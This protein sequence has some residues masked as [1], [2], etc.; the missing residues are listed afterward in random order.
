[1]DWRQKTCFTESN[2]QH[3]SSHKR[4]RKPSYANLAQGSYNVTINAGMYGLLRTLLNW[5]SSYC[6]TSSTAYQRR[7]GRIFQDANTTSRAENRSEK[8]EYCWNYI[9]RFERHSRY[10]LKTLHFD[11]FCKFLALCK[12]LTA[13][14]V[15]LTTSLAYKLQS[16]NVAV[17]MKQTIM[18]KNPRE[19]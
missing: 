15:M 3:T 1:M 6:M 12:K 9:F 17:P 7:G 5:R 18:E 14:A 10:R 19:A 13:V 2:A 16:N 8:P 11:S 4:L